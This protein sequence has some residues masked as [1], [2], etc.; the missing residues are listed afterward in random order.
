MENGV[1][2]SLGFPPE[3]TFSDA[4]SV[5]GDGSIIVGEYGYG[6]CGGTQA[7]VWDEIHGWRNLEY[8]L[9]MEYGIG[10][11][12]WCLRSAN[13]ISDDGT[14]RLWVRGQILMVMI[15]DGLQ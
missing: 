2:K 8:V 13:A 11:G 5:S 1:I 3:I 6:G 9:G 15:K 10:V 7:F 12:G 4:H 14:T